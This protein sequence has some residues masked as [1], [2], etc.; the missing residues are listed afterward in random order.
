[1][2]TSDLPRNGIGQLPRPRP[3]N[4]PTF[5]A[6]LTGT[7]RS[8]LTSCRIRII[9]TDRLHPTVNRPSGITADAMVRRPG[10]LRLSPRDA[11]PSAGRFSSRSP[12]VVPRKASRARRAVLF[13]GGAV[14]FRFTQLS[15]SEHSTRG[16]LDAL[17]PRSSPSARTIPSLRR[18]AFPTGRRFLEGAS[19]PT[20]QHDPPHRPFHPS[21]RL[22]IS[23]CFGCR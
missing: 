14:T 5:I 21:M 15:N 22:I 2:T 3:K 6:E 17:E 16:T 1:M 23:M 12:L 10:S 9:G 18:S 11:Y 4:T 8:Q 7:A 20:H 19:F 13:W